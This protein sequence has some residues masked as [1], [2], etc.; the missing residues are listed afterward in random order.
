MAVDKILEM[1]EERFAL[2]YSFRAFILRPFVLVFWAGHHM[3]EG[4]VEKQLLML[5]P[6]GSRGWHQ[7]R[8]EGWRE[9]RV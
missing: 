7:K 3:Q 8:G 2:A 1:R 5:W 6:T 4:V 9:L